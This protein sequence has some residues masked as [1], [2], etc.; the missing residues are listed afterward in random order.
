MNAT[1]LNRSDYFQLQ[2]SDLEMNICPAKK[3]SNP[4]NGSSK[5]GKE[6]A[7]TIPLR[8]DVENQPISGLLY[9]FNP[10]YTL[11]RLVIYLNSDDTS[12]VRTVIWRKAFFVVTDQSKPGWWFVHYRTYSGWISVSNEATNSGAIKKITSFRHYENWPGKNVFLNH[13]Q[14]ILGG[15]AKFF[16]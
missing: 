5:Q 15:D 3:V 1:K 8:S 4:L 12:L 13:G 11:S 14:F 16:L 7:L 6:E 10:S 2:D 9:R